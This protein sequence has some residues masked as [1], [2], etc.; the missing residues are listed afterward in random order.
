M[1]LSKIPVV[2]HVAQQILNFE[3][4]HIVI[5]PGSRNAP[6]TLSLTTHPEFS[7]YSVVDERSAGFFGLGLSQQLNEPVVLLCTSGSALLN[8]YPAV[9]E[10]FYS[11]IP[12]LV[13][14]ADR[15]TYQID[16]GNGQTIRQN[17]VF[18][19]SHCFFKHLCIKTLFTKQRQFWRVIL[20]IYCQVILQSLKLRII[21]RKWTI[22]MRKNSRKHYTV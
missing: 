9:A 13:I 18:F 20:K 22:V 7:T 4:K 6:L 17:N 14:S 3:I 16:I 8:F 21:K 10:A 1:N 5:C 11:R 2:R 12:L 19:K 15:P